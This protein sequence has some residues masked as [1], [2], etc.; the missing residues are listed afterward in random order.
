MAT[1]ADRRDGGFGGWLVVLR[2]RLRGHPPHRHAVRAASATWAAPTDPVG[3]LDRPAHAVRRDGRSGG[4]LR[5]ARASR[6]HVDGVLV[7]RRA[8]HAG[9]GH[10]SGRQPVGNAVPGTSSRRT[11]GTSTSGTTSGT[12]ASPADGRDAGRDRVG[13]S[14]PRRCRRTICSRCWSGSPTSP[15]PSRARRRCSAS[16]PRCVF[17]VW[18]CV[19]RDGLGRVLLTGYGFSLLLFAVFGIWQGGFPEFSA[20]RLD[21]R[22]PTVATPCR[23]LTHGTVTQQACIAC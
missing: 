15:T 9:S 10:P 11:S 19:T 20:A 7:R 13:A 1:Y 3:R 22:P 4:A 2:D 16:W 14:P 21:L 8:L 18:G 5:A 12:S 23:H 17:V 6:A